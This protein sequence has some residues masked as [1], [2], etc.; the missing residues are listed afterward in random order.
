MAQQSGLF[1]MASPYEAY[2]HGQALGQ[3]DIKNRD[4]GLK[5]TLE[6]QEL[7]GKIKADEQN[8][9]LNAQLNPHKVER[10]GLENLKLEEDTVA[11]R[12]L[13][14]KTGFEELVRNTLGTN[15]YVDEARL[16]QYKD[17][18]EQSMRMADNFSGIADE[19]S[20]VAPIMR[21]AVL[22]ALGRNLGLKEEQVESLSRLPPDEMPDLIRGLAKRAQENS[23][24]VIQE[25]LLADYKHGLAMKEIYAKGAYALKAAGMKGSEKD[26]DSFE[27][28]AVAF[29]MQAM[30][31]TDSNE[32]ARLLALSDEFTNLKY[33]VQNAGAQSTVGIKQAPGGG[34]AIDFRGDTAPSAM[35][36]PSV[37]NNMP[38]SGQ[39]TQ[40]PSATPAGITFTKDQQELINRYLPK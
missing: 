25:K 3:E 31:T 13:N 30:R 2:L 29:R 18:Y 36:P 19:I 32:R 17:R 14:K 21:P 24:K 11:Q 15:H 23:P 40:P 9:L 20:S 6:R 5:A 4:A 10:A 28:A 33:L 34:A 26:P 37:I 22:R 39:A 12:N 1:G 35:I 8:Y 7:E 16:K 38:T 27:K